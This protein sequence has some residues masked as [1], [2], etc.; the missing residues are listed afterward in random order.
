MGNMVECA[1]C[2]GEGWL[3]KDCGAQCEPDHPCEGCGSEAEKCYVCPG[4]GEL[5]LDD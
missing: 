5:E 3:C 2:G 1:E 4:E